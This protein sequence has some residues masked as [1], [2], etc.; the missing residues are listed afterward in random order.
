MVNHQAKLL[1]LLTDIDN[2]KTFVIIIATQSQINK[3]EAKEILRLINE[4]EN[5]ALN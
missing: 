4:A 2:I 1:R 3:R 5:R